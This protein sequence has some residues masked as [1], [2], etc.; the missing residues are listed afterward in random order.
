[1]LKGAGF[2]VSSGG[3]YVPGVFAPADV[4]VARCVSFSLTHLSL[5]LSLLP[6]GSSSQS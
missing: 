5:S 2:R 6:L 3:T 4:L 1:M